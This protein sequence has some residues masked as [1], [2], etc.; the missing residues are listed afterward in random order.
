MMNAPP[1]NIHPSGAE[2]AVIACT[3][4]PTTI[5]SRWRRWPQRD[6]AV[7]RKRRINFLICRVHLRYAARLPAP[8]WSR[9]CLYLATAASITNN[10]D[11]T[12]LPSK[13]AP[14]LFYLILLLLV[15]PS[16]LSST[17]S[18]LVPILQQC[19]I[20]IVFIF[21]REKSEHLFEV[22]QTEKKVDLLNETPENSLKNW[23]R[24]LALGS[25][26]IPCFVAIS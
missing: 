5:R 9:H 11:A 24:C 25:C 14:S 13:S 19:Q 8:S 1:A 26:K 4:E 17:F 16:D 7:K 23:K 22:S 6:K 15:S 2:C 20:P 21:Y 3:N 18:I 10:L 12:A